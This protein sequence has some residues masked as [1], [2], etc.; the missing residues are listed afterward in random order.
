MTAAERISAILDAKFAGAGLEHVQI[1]VTDGTL[2]FAKKHGWLRY[3]SNL[4]FSDNL[5][6]LDEATNGIPI[7]GEW[8][9]GD[10]ATARLTIEDGEQ[11]VRVIEERA[12]G[13]PADT[14]WQDVL[15][16]TVA[17]YARKPFAAGQIHHR[18]YYGFR[19]GTDDAKTGNIR[20][21]AER[22]SGWEP[23][24]AT[25]EEAE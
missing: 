11:K 7:A 24:P 8:L 20:R 22:M 12:I 17:V 19:P 25:D 13:T 4:Q 10:Q 16:E 5:E 15:A 21:L 18:I 2:D 9:I 23:L 6:E 3:Q 1:R 14:N